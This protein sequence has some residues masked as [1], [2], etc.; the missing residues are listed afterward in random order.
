MLTVL[1]ARLRKKHIAWIQSLII[2]TSYVSFFFFFHLPSAYLEKN[3]HNPYSRITY[4]STSHYTLYRF[5]EHDEPHLEH[6]RLTKDISFKYVN[7]ACHNTGWCKQA[8]YRKERT[9]TALN[10]MTQV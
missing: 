10:Y 2:V 4:E 7:M 3:I 9:H 1:Y 6:T 5:I 8:D